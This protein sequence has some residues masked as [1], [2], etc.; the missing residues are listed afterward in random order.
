[1]ERRVREDPEEKR[2]TEA[3]EARK[4][5]FCGDAVARA[6]GDT[7]EIRADAEPESGHAAGGD[8]VLEDANGAVD[9]RGAAMPQEEGEENAD[10]EVEAPT[11][12]EARGAAEAGAG[13]RGATGAEARGAGAR[14]AT[15]AEAPGA[16]AR[17]ATGA[18]ARGAAEE[19]DEEGG[20]S[21]RRRLAALWQPDGGEP[22]LICEAFSPPRVAEAARSQ[23]K[24]GGWSLDFRVT[25]PITRRR[26]N[27]A[28]G[29]DFRAACRLLKEGPPTL[30]ILC[31][32]YA[33]FNGRTSE[34]AW[35][36]GCHLFRRALALIKLQEQ[37]KG[38][39]ALEH[40]V[41]SKAWK[42]PES[43]AA[44]QKALKVVVSQ[45]LSRPTCIMTNSATVR[46][47]LRHTRAQGGV[48]R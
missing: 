34:E 37:M 21:K 39:W 18:E 22:P 14:G 17:G 40:P 3:A 47:Q 9:D 42:F 4:N 26:W 25:C 29:R 31:P 28:S 43:Q 45:C 33:A 48:A 12:A 15:S 5:R 11:G 36:Y 20:D 23:G 38:A 27:L 7:T 41:S 6:A 2:V 35:E 30:L 44:F 32:P 10:I 19:E 46:D 8:I 16:G 1:M 24:A 13:A